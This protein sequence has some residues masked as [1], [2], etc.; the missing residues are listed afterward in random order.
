MR[1]RG[2]AVKK[3]IGREGDEEQEGQT[4]DHGPRTTDS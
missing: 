2:G 4:T 3:E 1:G